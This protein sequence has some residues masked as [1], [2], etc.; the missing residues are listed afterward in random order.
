M[1]PLDSH[2]HI[3][4]DIAPEQ[5]V[6]LNAC[7]LAMT[8]SLD[9]FQ[10]AANRTDPTTA[11]GVGCHPALAKAQRAFSAE[12]LA[13]LVP[14]T[15][16]IGEVGL[17]GSSRVPM[18][19]QREVFGQVLDVMAQAPRLSS[20]HSYRAA[21][22]VL[23]ELTAHQPLRGVI[24]HWWLGN[25]VQTTQA[26]HLGCWFSVNPSSVRHA[27]G[28]HVPPDRILTETD[29]PYG[30]RY[31]P[32]S[33]PGLVSAVESSLARHYGGTSESI[34]IQVWRNLTRLV[35]E[36]GCLNLLPSSI[37]AHLVPAA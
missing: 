3:V 29:H 37:R 28:A 33:R 10:A 2:A 15:A 12:L 4:P 1:L 21:S 16:I 11:W 7:V 27:V 5:L 36:V 20:V 14:K 32:G 25:P 31:V 30:D 17:D 19:K 26:V 34:R 8:R 22:E 13:S 35:R 18:E 23:E 24:L 9:E 6:E